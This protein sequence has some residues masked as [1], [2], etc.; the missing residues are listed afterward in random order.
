MVAQSLLSMGLRLPPHLRKEQ[1][2][3]LNPAG[4][5]PLSGNPSS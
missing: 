2:V 4:T 1:A 5:G 3:P